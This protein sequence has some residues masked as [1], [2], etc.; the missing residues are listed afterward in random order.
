[1]NPKVSIIIPV[2]N[3]EKYIRETLESVV[4]QS[5]S[6]FEVIC[7]DNNSTDKTYVI[8]KDY[9]KKDKRFRI[10]HNK[11]NIKQGLARNFGVEQANGKYIFFLDGDDLLEKDAIKKLYNKISQDDTDI[12]ICQWSLLDD[13]TKKI[14]TKHDYALLK[15]IPKE[16]EKKTFSWRD[17]KDSVFWQT[18]VPWDK[19]YKKDFLLNKNVKFP[20]GTFFEDNVFAYDALFKAEKISILKEQLVLY[21]VNRKGA[22]TNTKDRT[23]FD[24]LKIFNM[25]GENLKKINLYNE[26][27]YKYF[28]YKVITLYWWYQKIKLPYKKE[29]FEQIKKDFENIDIKQEEKEFIRNRTCF[30]LSR[31]KKFPF[32]LYYPISFF[33]KIY[34]IERGGKNKTHILLSTFEK[35]VNY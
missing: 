1:M 18:S 10:F 9:E 20:G 11:E 2:Y 28:D 8:L 23:F 16:L 32:F 13:K 14:N 3:I 35:W 4:S 26:M 27:K 22:V 5:F 31:F 7:V 25:I 29:F 12:T 19:I 17:I 33:D 21:R 24:Y 34:R 30:L 15:Q 6:D